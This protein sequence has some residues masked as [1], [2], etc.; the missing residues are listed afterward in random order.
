MAGIMLMLSFAMG[1][2]ADDV[3]EY[4]PEPGAIYLI[5]VEGL[6]D[7][8]LHKYIQ[9]GLSQAESNQA[10]G[11][12]LY[13]DT[14]G[15]LVDAADNIR[16]DLLDNDQLIISFIDK[17]A[18]SAGALIALATDSIY[19]APGSS[20]GAATVVDGSGTYASEKMQS[21]MRGI[22][23]A[24]AEATGRDPEVAEAMVDERVV[25]EGLVEDGQLLTLS[26]TE[27]LGIGLADGSFRDVDELLEYMEWQDKELVDFQEFWAESVLRFLAN[28]VITSLLMLMMLGGLYF[29]LQ[30]PGVGFPGAI[31]GVGALLFFAPMY[32]MGLAESW[33]ILL[34]LLGVGLLLV[35]V[36]VIPG[37]GV[38]GIAGITLV[39]FSMGASIIGNVGLRFPEMHQ[40]TQ[41]IW[42]MAITLI[43][44]VGMIASMIRYLPE[45]RMF[46]KLVLADQ[47]DRNHGYT[48][49]DSKDDLM[50]LEGV[51]LTSLRPAGTV[52]IQERRVDVVSVGE[53]I[54]KGAQVKVVDTSGSRV[55]VSRVG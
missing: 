55:M 18:A 23:R 12:I 1:M 36:F 13:I 8:G 26:T 15:G 33:E 22:M 19:M 40:I 25:I 45:N 44:G 42:T 14:F 5:H 4:I 9:R 53:F 17:N 48:S 52:L 2:N 16:K 30:S 46:N 32:I 37:F 35:E 6:I 39:I 11:I 54:E 24:T 50:G 47:T 3:D 31:S 7:N 49:S 20:I 28:P 10:S 38:P 34:F 43:L 21:Y 27:A 29:E 51:A 41:A